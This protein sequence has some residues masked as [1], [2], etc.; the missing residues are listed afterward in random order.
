MKNK[1]NKKKLI[2]LGGYGVG[3]IAASIAENFY[4]FETDIFK[5]FEHLLEIENFGNKL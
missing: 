4:N 3:M 1:I 2:I 5:K